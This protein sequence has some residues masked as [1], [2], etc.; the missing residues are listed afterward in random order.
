MYSSLSPQGQ[1]AAHAV[2]GVPS[3]MSAEVLS[4]WV[5]GNTAANAAPSPMPYIAAFAVP[6]ASITARM[7][8]IR[9]SRSGS[10]VRRSDM[11]TPRLSK[12]MT[13]EKAARPRRKAA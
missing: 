10:E 5:A 2:R 4:G 9:D 1:S 3:K 12:Q 11:P 8:S 13:R 6:V 7:S